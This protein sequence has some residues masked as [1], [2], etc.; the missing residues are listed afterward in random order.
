MGATSQGGV[1]GRGLE[2]TRSGARLAHR[3]DGLDGIT[4]KA[5][6]LALS[7]DHARYAPKSSRSAALCPVRVGQLGSLTNERSRDPA[8]LMMRHW[9]V[10]AAPELDHLHAD[11]AWGKATSSRKDS[12]FGAELPQAGRSGDAGLLRKGSSA[13][14]SCGTWCLCLVG[15]GSWEPHRTPTSRRHGGRSPQESHERNGTLRYTCDAC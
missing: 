10:E 3:R 14:A 6:R 4:T 12:A 13:S 7:F 5:V 2:E 9:A 11:A 8:D 15:Q 1:V